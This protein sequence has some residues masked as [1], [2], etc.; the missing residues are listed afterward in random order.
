VSRAAGLIPFSAYP[1]LHMPL[2]PGALLCALGLLAVAGFP[3]LDRR[4]IAP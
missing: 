1:S 2:A 3:F 4:G